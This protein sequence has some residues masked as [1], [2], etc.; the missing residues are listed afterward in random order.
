MKGTGFAKFEIL[1]KNIEWPGQVFAST[2][3]IYGEL[4][5][6]LILSYEI[7]QDHPHRARQ[8]KN[9]LKYIF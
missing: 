2:T 1:I 8:P 6:K 9:V 7:S 3:F 5:L 4:L